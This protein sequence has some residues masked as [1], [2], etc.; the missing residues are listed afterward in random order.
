LVIGR[1]S[2]G[3]GLVQRELMLPDESAVRITTAKYYT[4]SGRLIQKPFA[5]GTEE[6]HQEIYARYLHGE[7]SNSDSISFPDSLK[8]STLV[9]KRVVF[10]GGGIMPDIFV[11]VDTSFYTDYYRDILRNGLLNEFVL[12]YID[13]NRFKMT[14]LYSDF[15]AFNTQF[16]IDNKLFEQFI[17]YAGK[18][19]IARNDQEIEISKPQIENMLKALIARDLFGSSEFYQIFNSTNTIYI[20]A[21]EVLNS[22]DSYVSEL[23]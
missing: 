12:E 8:Y 4:P 7:L 17:T 10:G 22:W 19:K 23:L 14:K 2:F 3:K 18:N 11:P 20:K 5:N 15:E 9:K 1:R 6:Y 13:V 21:L 16:T